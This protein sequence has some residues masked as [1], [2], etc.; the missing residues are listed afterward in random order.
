MRRFFAAFA[1]VVTP[2]TPRKNEVLPEYLS[3]IK[4][5][6]LVTPVTR[7]NDNIPDNFAHSDGGC[8]DVRHYEHDPE[9]IAA[10]M[11]EQ[12]L[13]PPGTLER[14]KEDADHR[15]VCAGLMRCADV[16]LWME[17]KQ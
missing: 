5:V 1:G 15:A 3:N 16:K 11:N 13:P 10:R 7:K 6:T 9:E 8:D 14:E 12:R 4:A 17:G 2:V